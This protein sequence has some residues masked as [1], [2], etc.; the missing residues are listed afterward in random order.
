VNKLGKIL[1]LVS[2][3][4]FIFGFGLY[5]FIS[6]DRSVSFWENRSLA[7]KPA[8]STEA[9]VDGSYMSAYETYFTDQFPLRDGWMKA[10]VVFENVTKQTYINDYY[11]AADHILAKP[12][13]YTA[14]QNLNVSIEQMNRLGDTAKNAGS[15]LYFFY[16]PSR[17]IVLEDMY[18][19]FMSKGYTTYSKDY[20]YNG[21][22]NEHVQKFDLSTEFINNYTL[23]ERKQLFYQT[24]HHWN[25][26]GAINGYEFIHNTLANTSTT[27]NGESFNASNYEKVCAAQLNFV[28]SYNLQLY[29]LIQDHDDLACHYVSKKVNYDSDYTIYS[30]N[31]ANNGV[32][33][34][35][36][37]FGSKMKNTEGDINYAEVFMQDYAEINIVNN[38]KVQAGETSK[39]LIIK[40]SFANAVN[41]LVAEN[42]AQTSILDIRYFTEMTIEQYI[43]THGFDTIIILYN[44]ETIFNSMYNFNGQAN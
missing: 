24:D 44:G 2:F 4:M 42:F 26:E 32:V 33:S 34:A 17:V 6:E 30:G 29:K 9:V 13:A 38:Q 3:L 21:V 7:Q 5:A 12:L 25:E 37:L 36:G 19:S 22:T 18:P 16:L 11:V 23:E 41:L 14:D 1:M 31:V 39:A 15:E 10:H 8:F 28:G 35:S 20:L 43:Q 27:V 40:D